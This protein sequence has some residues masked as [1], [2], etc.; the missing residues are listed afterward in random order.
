MNKDSKVLG[1]TDLE[2][3]KYYK[4]LG[5]NIDYEMTVG[6]GMRLGK[7]Y[8]VVGFSPSKQVIFLTDK[9]SN[10]AIFNINYDSERK[11]FI[12]AESFYQPR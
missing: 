12:K 1:I 4:F 7:V 2:A 5:A 6:T 8:Y 9:D 10:H 11:K 3:G